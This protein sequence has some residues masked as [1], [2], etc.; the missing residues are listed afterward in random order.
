[1]I[2]KEHLIQLY[3]NGNLVE[4]ESQDSIGMRFNNVLI[5]PTKIGSEQA[6]YS[7]EFEI[8]C[9]KKNNSIFDFANTLSKLNKFHNRYN[10][11]V[12]ADGV[13]IFTGTLVINSIKDNKYNVNLVSVKVYSLDEIFGDLNLSQIPWHIPFSGVTS[14]NE[15]NNSSDVVK[16]PLASYGVFQKDPYHS[17]NVANDYTSKFVLDKYNK[18]YIPSFYPSVNMLET[19]KKAFEWKGYTCNGD[20]YNDDN[21]KNIFM[22]TNLDSDQVPTYNIG[23]PAFGKVDIDVSAS[24]TTTTT[25]YQQELS[26]PYFNV[27]SSTGGSEY[28]WTDINVYSLM[29]IGSVA[30]N[31]TPSYMYQPNE[32]LIVIP[33]DGFYKIN[34]SATTTLNAS[35]SFSSHTWEK[36]AF[37]YR[38]VDEQL[39]PNLRE[40]TPVEIQ[41]VRNYND[42]IELIKGRDNIRYADGNPNNSES[43]NRIIW[44]TCYPHEDPYN[45]FLPTEKNDLSWVNKSRMG[46]NRSSSDYDG[47]GRQGQRDTSTTTS[48]SGNF[49]GYRGGTRAGTID[50]TGGGR[51]WSESM[52]G[53]VYPYNT[54]MM[55]DQAVSDTFLCGMSSFY[56]GCTAVIKNGY[57]W[58]RSYN[59]KQDAFYTQNG[60]NAYYRP[61]G[62]S[63]FTE[64]ATT[65][66]KNSYSGAPTASFSKTNQD[67]TMTGS[68][69]C[70]VWL[71]KDDVL[72]LMEVHR[73]HYYSFNTQ[74]YYPTTTNVHLTIE[75]A[76]P[77]SYNSIKT[78]MD[79]GYYSY[80]SATEFETELNLGN[81][82]NSGTSISSFIQGVINAFNLEMT[83]NG[84]TVSIDKKKKFESNAATVINI[85]DRV[86]SDEAESNRID[87][88]KSMA[89]KYKI[90]TEEWGFEKTVP[91]DKINEPDWVNYGDS[92][93]TVIKLNDDSY[94]TDESNVSLNYSY[95]YYD[96]F[97]WT[98]VDQDHVEDSGTTTTLN[99]PVMSKATYMVDGYSYDESMKHDGYSLTQRLWYKPQPKYYTGTTKAYVWTDTYPQ[100]KIDI[101]TPVNVFN[102]LNLSYKN[103]EKS[104][105]EYFNVRAFLESNYVTVDVYLTP[106]EYKLLSNGAKVRFDSDL[107]D[108]VSIDGYDPSGDNTAELKLIK[109]V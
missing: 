32:R 67:K 66:N 18:W 14:I 3:V 59:A 58:S 85:D 27:K 72:E 91:Q 13:V 107:Y 64:S 7:F 81:F 83:Q 1:M 99:I 101:Y 34:L 103:T 25:P 92:G 108:V 56:S 90:D 19:V 84:N 48:S 54:P 26:F 105:L 78:R 50:R 12:Y 35:G 98:K 49:S 94:A 23:N 22:S 52:N 36:Y 80:S 4:L 86:S 93:Y 51:Q 46:G 69:S 106:D 16:F 77:K 42:N 44:T 17:D 104:L 102:G 31:Q 71:N 61:Q 76:S 88:P 41:L 73:G 24:I 74:Y 89:V 37:E 2:Y 40:T 10:A 60:Y 47:S 65:F 87:Y 21:L 30:S 70:L 79:E 95:T 20:A 45:A 6:S 28:N 75:A 39:Y 57:S 100:E 33:A 8:P 11:E 43:G 9:T 109:R 82:L 55:Y 29:S 68:I 5:N 38:E 53:Y 96:N 97:T 63:S 62:S 15:Y